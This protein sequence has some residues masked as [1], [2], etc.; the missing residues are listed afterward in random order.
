MDQFSLPLHVAVPGPLNKVALSGA[1]LRKKA[2]CSHV[3]NEYP[4]D[5]SLSPHARPSQMHRRVD[6]LPIDRG[7]DEILEAISVANVVILTSDTGSG[8]TTRVPQYVLDEQQRKGQWCRIVVTEQRRVAAREAAKRVAYERGEDLRAGVSGRTS[9]GYAVKDDYALPWA[10]D[11]FI[12]VTEEKFLRVF[13]K[14][15]FT[16]IFVDEGHERYLT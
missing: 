15:G 16:H 12:Y 9:V 13:D 7:S 4:F 2:K 10:W 14:G 11:S 8:K 5:A 6:W 1:Q 3:Q